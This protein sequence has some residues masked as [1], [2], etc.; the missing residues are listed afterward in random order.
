MLMDDLLYDILTQFLK[1]FPNH[2]SNDDFSVV[3]TANKDLD[4]TMRRHL[5]DLGET[6]ELWDGWSKPDSQ[7]QRSN[8]ESQTGWMA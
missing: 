4:P 7:G 1:W 6:E 8:F 2:Q 5:E 3:K